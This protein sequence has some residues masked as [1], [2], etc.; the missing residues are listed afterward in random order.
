MVPPDTATAEKIDDSRQGEG[1]RLG[2]KPVDVG[3][4]AEPCHLALGEAA[5][6]S[7]RLLDRPVEVDLPSEVL[8][9]LTVPY[10][11]ERR[12]ARIQTGC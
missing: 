11:L 2:R 5:G 6:R 3:L 8:G 1:Q 7:D 12:R 10:R 9:E 4:L